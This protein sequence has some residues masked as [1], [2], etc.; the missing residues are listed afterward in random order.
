MSQPFQT[1]YQDPYAV[2]TPG[3]GSG[4]LDNLDPLW[5]VVL[6]AVALAFFLL[7]L[8]AIWRNLLQIAR[9][10]EALI[11]SGK[12]YRL[13]DGTVLGYRVVSGGRRALRIPILERVD[14]MD[15][16]L[17]PIDIV[18]HNA[19]S[20]GN[21]P[22]QIHAIA[23]VK[24]DSNP[25]FITNAIER[26]LGRSH[27]EIQQVSKQ[28]LEG[29]LREVLAQMTPEEVNEDRLKFAANLIHAAE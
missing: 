27:T 6:G 13:E 11:F 15:M 25:K 3:P 26:F 22:L 29:A 23:N 19:Y 12:K 2:P 18:V 14:R 10:N 4:L 16:T 17:I 1:Q 7:I 20:K 8:I 28:T 5:M 21:I 24:I 9:P